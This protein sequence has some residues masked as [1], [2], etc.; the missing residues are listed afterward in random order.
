MMIFDRMTPALLTPR[1]AAEVLR[2]SE[3]TLQRIRGRGLPYVMPSP[4][5][6]LYR[7]ADIVSLSRRFPHRARRNRPYLSSCQ[8][9]PDCPWLARP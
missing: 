9:G 6:I 4:G 3:K 7:A 5:K 1:Q 2:V 8:D